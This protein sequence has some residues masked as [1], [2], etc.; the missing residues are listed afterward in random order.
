MIYLKCGHFEFEYF[1]WIAL[2]LVT[3]INYKKVK[4]VADQ[5][6]MAPYFFYRG[7]AR[8][9]GWLEQSSLIKKA[10]ELRFEI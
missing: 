1:R 2:E 7:S 9:L 8:V 10:K 6:K 4:R 5:N 3:N